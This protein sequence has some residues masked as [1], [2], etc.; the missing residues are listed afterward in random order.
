MRQ[1]GVVIHEE[2]GGRSRKTAELTSSRHRGKSKPT[3]YSPLILHAR[4]DLDGALRSLAPRYA[5][6]GGRGLGCRCCR[7]GKQT[8]SHAYSE[9]ATSTPGSLLLVQMQFLGGP[10]R[11]NVFQLPNLASAEVAPICERLLGLDPIVPCILHEGPGDKTAHDASHETALESG[12]SGVRGVGRLCRRGRAL[13]GTSA[14]GCRRARRLSGSTACGP[15]GC[16][17][18]RQARGGDGSAGV[19]WVLDRDDDGPFLARDLHVVALEFCV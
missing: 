19:A 3:G 6:L 17:R 16:R 11:F 1:V 10:R 4:C 12:P 14:S 9:F 7:V 13:R 2:E 15:S 18:G 8:S 5:S